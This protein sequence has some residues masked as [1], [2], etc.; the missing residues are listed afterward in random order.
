MGLCVGHSDFIYDRLFNHIIQ[1]EEHIDITS[2]ASPNESGKLT[3]NYPGTSFPDYEQFGSMFRNAIR[4]LDSTN[5]PV[6]IKFL[7]GSTPQNPI[8]EGDT[9]FN[10]IRFLNDLLDGPEGT[11]DKEKITLTGN[12]K[13]YAATYRISQFSWNHGKVIA[14]DGKKVFTGGT[15]YYPFD[16]LQEDPVF[17]V[18]I[19]VSNGPAIAA[20]KYAAKLWT[21]V[22]EWILKDLGLSHVEVAWILDNEK[23]DSAS[24]LDADNC[25]PVFNVKNTPNSYAGKTQGGA[26]VIQA[27]RLGKL[28]EGRLGKL[29]LGFGQNSIEHGQMTS[30][31][32]MVA[33]M[34]SAK[35]SIKFSQQDVL[36]FIIAGKAARWAGKGY[37][38]DCDKEVC[39]GMTE[40]S[41][42][43]TWRKIGSIAK[44][45]SREVKISMMV[46]A[47]CAF[48]AA[49]LAPVGPGFKNLFP[50][51]TNGQPSKGFDYWGKVYE[52]HNQKWPSP[53]SMHEMHAHITESMSPLGD[54]SG[55]RRL[56]YGYG[57]NLDNINDW[58]FAYYAINKQYRPLNNVTS[59]SMN[60]DEILDHICRFVSIG[61]VRLTANEPTYMRANGKGGQIGNHAKI[62]MVD[63]EAFYIGSDNAYGAGLAEFGLIIDDEE[64]TEDFKTNYWDVLWNEAKGTT[65]EPGL[66]SGGG[67]NDC[68]WK[69]DFLLT[70]N[71]QIK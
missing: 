4:Y 1:A 48:G 42:E 54:M 55:R 40:T 30:D 64:R 58:I 29:A 56:S 14:V 51:P 70:K 28:A 23:P 47:P 61:H 7:F 49:K 3:M 26:M 12:L 9:N 34:E 44:A 2:L 71:W 22:C 53:Q 19:M 27:A 18:D 57:W 11:P 15:N 17:D 13:I 66:R 39:N 36:P 60:S 21:P 35:D 62:V 10:P 50:C 41:F 69:K 52:H 25:P 24:G 32:A 16:Y 37:D 59:I 6:T 5:R 45:L 38:Y 31:L 65:E 46:S 33:M 68:P 8:D 43:E 67:E 20:H 63:D